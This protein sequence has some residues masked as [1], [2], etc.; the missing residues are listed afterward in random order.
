M[1]PSFAYSKHCLFLSF[2][3]GYISKKDHFNNRK[4]SE[5]HNWFDILV[6][7]WSVLT[8][9]FRGKLSWYSEGEAC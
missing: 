9:R 4:E 8:R 5:D 7:D 3:S 6:P 2:R 1:A